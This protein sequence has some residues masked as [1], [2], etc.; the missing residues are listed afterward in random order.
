[1]ATG[2]S[3]PPVPTQTP[4]LDKDSASGMNIDWIKWFI[5][6]GVFFSNAAKT[7]VASFNGRSGA[8]LPQAGDYPPALGGTGQTNWQ[9]GNLLVGA[10]PSTTDLLAVGVNA[11]VLTADS[12]SPDGVKWS[13]PASQAVSSVFG[14]VGAVTASPGDYSP[15]NGGT[16]QT[17]WVKGNLLVGQAV[18][19][20]AVLPPGANTQSLVYDSTALNGIRYL[21]YGDAVTPTGVVDGVN[22][23]FTLPDSP[24]PALSLQ[25]FLNSGGAGNYILQNGLYVLAGNTITY[26]TAPIVA[27]THLAWYRA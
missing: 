16:G 1:M 12:G 9:K 27:S 21:K 2:S 14:R 6:V 17:S 7:L 10:G 20:T 24:S 4:L 18:N 26:T 22:K 5:A 23:V 25:L 15:Q 8:V 3:F 13:L 11:A 19:V